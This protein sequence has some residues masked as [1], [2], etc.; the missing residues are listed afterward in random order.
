ML[1]AYNLKL[2]HPITGVEMDIFAPL[3]KDMEEVAKK[4]GFDLEGLFVERKEGVKEC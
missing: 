3:P 1:H 2:N 4:I